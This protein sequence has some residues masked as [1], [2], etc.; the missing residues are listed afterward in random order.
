MVAESHW[1][2]VQERGSLL[3][4]RLLIAIHRLG[5]G[6]LFRLGLAPVV[7]FYAVFHTPAR[8]ASLDY[9]RRM[10]RFNPAFPQPRPWHVIRHLWNFAITLYDKLAVWRGEISRSDVTFHR[11]EIIDELLAAK[12]GAVMLI[13]HLGNFEICQ[14]LSQTRPELRLTVLHHT[15]HAAKFNRV[16]GG[17][18]RDSPVELLQVADLDVA[19]AI[20]LNERISAGGF[21]AIAADRV[22][23]GTAAK[24]LS[25]DFL[26]HPAQFPVGPFALALALQAPVLSLH[27]IKQNGRYHIHFDCLWRGGKV[28]RHH[29]HQRRDALLDAYVDRLETFCLAAPWQ[30]YNFFPFW[31]PAQQAP[32]QGGAQRSPPTSLTKDTLP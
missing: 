31:A 13:S 29:R 4:M 8:R 26:G 15:A 2:G 24:S 23:I 16:L 11:S 21:I 10:H 5:G 12:R 20:G 3:G 19:A 7:C 28:A 9:L 30:W 18:N 17:Y 27:C 14:A 25:K 1:A 32:Q 22:A 6:W